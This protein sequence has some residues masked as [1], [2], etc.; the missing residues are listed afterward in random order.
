MGIVII[1]LAAKVK[2]ADIFESSDDDIKRTGRNA[3]YLMIIFAC[4]AL[5]LSALG[6]VTAKWHKW[7]LVGC[8]SYI[9]L[10]NN[11]I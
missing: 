2:E 5:G 9:L 8:V 11:I 4:F 10:V 1:I 6:F 3:F 7:Q